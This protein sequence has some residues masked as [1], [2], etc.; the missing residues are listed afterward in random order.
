VPTEQVGKIEY[1]EYAAMEGKERFQNE[2]YHV[3]IM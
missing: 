2:G 1:E 3:L